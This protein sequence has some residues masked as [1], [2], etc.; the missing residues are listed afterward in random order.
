[1]YDR[2]GQKDK[3][4]TDDRRPLAVGNVAMLRVLSGGVH[5]LARAEGLHKLK[6][7]SGYGLH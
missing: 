7:C 2:V 1:M 6:A 5:R 4:A 3:E